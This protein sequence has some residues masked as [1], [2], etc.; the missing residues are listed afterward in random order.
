M[1]QLFC[2]TADRCVQW[3]Q[4]VISHPV[5]VGATSQQ[6][7]GSLALPAVACAPECVGDVLR[8]R[9]RNISKIRRH[10]RQQS[11]R[12]GLPKRGL[13]T[14]LDQS[15]CGLPLP[16]GDRVSQWRT[17]AD[18]TATG[19]DIRATI[20]QGIE[21]RNVIGACRPVQRRFGM[22][23]DESGV[24]VGA[25]GDQFR[26]AGDVIGKMAGPVRGDVEEGALSVDCRAD[27]V[28]VL[29]QCLLERDDVTILDRGD[30]DRGGCPAWEPMRRPVRLDRATRAVH[31]ANSAT[32]G[33][34]IA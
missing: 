15:P 17:A 4:S 6:E 9:P 25:G 34:K 31:V 27:K 12:R 14:P 20:K 26:D 11:Q 7:F 32:I 5:Q 13:C 18:D 2:T 24:D 30:D 1:G 22:A 28:V 23:A 3:R 33:M 16:E 21:Y 29:P 8:C 19:F 10:A